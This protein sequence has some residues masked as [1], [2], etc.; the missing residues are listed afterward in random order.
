MEARA[1]MFSVL[2]DITR[3]YTSCC[4]MEP[5]IMVTAAPMKATM[6][7]GSKLC[8][9]E[10]LP[11][12]AAWLITTS[13]PPAMSPISQVRYTRPATMMIICMKSVRATDH[14]PPKR[15]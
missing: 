9:K 1:A 5:N 2:A 12:A 8:M 11:S 13:A 6:S 15:V 4:G 14:M 3:A 10:N 7:L